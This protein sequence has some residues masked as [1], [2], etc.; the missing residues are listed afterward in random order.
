MIRKYEFFKESLLLEQIINESLICYSPPLRN[1][2]NKMKSKGYD[3]ADELIKIEK[4]D[5]KPDITF[6]DISDEGYFSFTTMKKVEDILKN[7]PNIEKDVEFDYEYIISHSDYFYSIRGDSNYPFYTKNRNPIKIGRFINRVLNKKYKEKDIEDFVNELKS[8]IFSDREHFEIVSGDDISY[9]YDSNHYYDGNG[10]LGSS[11]MR[12]KG[13]YIFEIYVKNPEVCKM[14]ILLKENKLIGRAILWK[15]SVIKEIVSR[16]PIILNEN[17]YFMD[18]VYTNKDSLLNTFIRYADDNDFLHKTRNTYSHTYGVMDKGGDNFNVYMEVELN[19]INYSNFPYM[20]TFKIYDPSSGILNNNID[21]V[22]DYTYEGFYRLESTGGYYEVITMCYYSEYYDEMIPRDESVWSDPL[23][24]YIWDSLAVEVRRSQNNSFMGFYP[25]DHDSIIYSEYSDEYYHKAD[26]V[27]SEYYC[28]YIY[29]DDAYEC[30]TNVDD[31]GKIVNSNRNYV[32]DCDINIVSMDKLSKST[33]DILKQNDSKWNQYS[34]ISDSILIQSEVGLIPKSISIEVYKC[35]NDN[36]FEYLSDIDSFILD[37]EI[38]K[39][40][41]KILDKFTYHEQ[42]DLYR[43]FFIDKLKYK[44][45]LIKD[46]VYKKIDFKDGNQ[47]DGKLK[48]DF[49][50]FLYKNRMKDYLYFTHSS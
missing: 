7:I 4:T 30:V 1:I 40:N 48:K 11:C 29:Y 21:E 33:L 13:D 50:L 28:D 24:D 25:K 23:G 20:D 39:N 14:L 49:F 36:R 41:K 16:R 27:Y 18:R 46:D 12:N 6:V 31:Y 5:V 22:D 43:K 32:L 8:V 38:Y 3:I 17:Q 19:K 10:T 44:Q 37:I 26:V 47:F 15:P 34:V 2:L 42:L 45:N 35:L 9:W